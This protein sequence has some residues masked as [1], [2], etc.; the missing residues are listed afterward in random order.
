MG[1]KPKK[2]KSKEKCEPCEM[3]IRLFCQVLGNDVQSDIDRCNDIMDNSPNPVD[4][5]NET[6]GSEIVEENIKGLHEFIDEELKDKTKA[7]SL[8]KRIGLV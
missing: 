2:T 1:N 7:K 8:M 3:P 4:D 6:F 5:L